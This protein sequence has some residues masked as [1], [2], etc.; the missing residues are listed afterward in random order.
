M[1]ELKIY[2][3]TLRD[4]AQRDGISYSVGEKITIAKL[5]DNLG[6]DYLEGGWPGSNPKDLE[7]FFRARKTAFKN[8]KIA[9]FGS[10][11]HADAKVE[12]DINVKQLLEA[13]T[14][15]VTIFGKSWDFHVTEALRT[16]LDENLL[17]IK[18]SVSYLKDK[19]KEVIY[20]AEHFFDG[21]CHNPDYALATIKAAEAGGADTIVLCDTNGGMLPLQLQ[22]IIRQVKKVVNAPLG[23]HAHNDAGMGVANSI[24]A[25]Q[26]GVVHIQGTI[27]GYGERC[28]NADLC[29]IIPNIQYKLGY[30]VLDENKLKNLRKIS[31]TVAEL[32]NMVPSASQP[33]V[34]SNAF[35]HKGGVHVD[36]VLKHPETYEHFNPELVGNRRRILVSELSGKSNILYKAN[37][38]NIKLTK[39]YPETKKILETIKRME[40]EGYQ[41]EVAEGSFELLLWKTMKAYKPLFTL[42]GF[43]VINEKY[44]NNDGDMISEATVK[45][46]VG[47]Q[48]V[49]TVAEGNGPVNALDQALRKALE[50]IY[51]ALKKIKLVDYKVRVL[52]GRE[53]T[54]AKVRVLNFSR[55]DKKQWG[56]VGVSTNIIEASWL[57]LVDSIEY[58]ILC[59]QGKS[60]HGLKTE[61]LK[62]MSEE[63]ELDFSWDIAD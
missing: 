48:R 5:L 57:A 1:G 23:I 15:V 43:R 17:M 8:I 46:I 13:E 52:E 26:S 36:A 35:T 62:R 20:D 33:Y 42:E 22:E 25:F 27:N 50:D 9:A 53:G 11:R 39:Q 16:S 31:Y 32:A 6:L 47:N 21:Y 54:A 10:T 45:I 3:T 2:D 30:K 18:E 12:E 63:L 40:Y 41:F 49:H 38:M 24:I 60:P 7:F 14:E 59:R 61:V 44:K 29:T 51:P 37:E 56:T 55:D 19:G 34:G 4:G 58:G 28:G